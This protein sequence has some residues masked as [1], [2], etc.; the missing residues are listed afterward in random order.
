MKCS[1]IRNQTSQEIEGVFAE[2]GKSSKLYSDLVDK[3]NDPEQALDRWA[4][5]LTPSFADTYDGARDE[6]GEPT[7]DEVI[8]RG[9]IDLTPQAT[10]LK[11][12]VNK[13]AEKTSQGYR[14][15]ETKS[16]IANRVTDIVQKYRDDIRAYSSSDTTAADIGTTVHLL[17]EMMFRHFAGEKMNKS[18]RIAKVRDHLVSAGLPTKWLDSLNSVQINDLEKGMLALYEDIKKTQRSIDPEGKVAILTEHVVHNKIKDLAGTIDV[19]IVYSNGQT[20]TLD[21]KTM[22][23]S[24]TKIG[25]EEMVAGSNKITEWNIQQSNYKQMLLDILGIED[26]RESRIIPIAVDY[27]RYD[28]KSES[29]VNLDSIASITMAGNTESRAL[30]PIP[31]AG[32]LTGKPATDKA[33]KSLERKRS[34]LMTEIRNAKEYRKKQLLKTKIN[35]VDKVLQNLRLYDDVKDATEMTSNLI[36]EIERRMNIKEKGTRSYLV[37][38]DIREYINEI[39]F[40]VEILQSIDPKSD[41][42]EKLSKMSEKEMKDFV[43]KNDF[44]KIID[45]QQTLMVMSQAQNYKVVLE[46]LMLDRMNEEAGDEVDLKHTGKKPGMMGRLFYGIASSDSPIFQRFS[47]LFTTARD[48]AESDTFEDIAYIKRVDKEFIGWAKSNGMT[49]QE[50]FNLLINNKTK[51]LKTSATLEYYDDLKKARK[52]KDML[53]FENN[54]GFNEEAFERDQEEYLKIFDDPSFEPSSFFYINKGKKESDADFKK[55]L[56]EKVEEAK[57]EFKERNDVRDNNIGAY[58]TSRYI[59]PKVLNTK[60][61]S[62]LTILAEKP[63]NEAFKNYYNMYTELNEKYDKLTGSEKKIKRNFIANV[64][65]D[66]TDRMFE[67]GFSE[68]VTGL[69]QS[70]THSLKIREQDEVVG[71]TDTETGKALKSVPILYT[72]EIKLPLTTKEEN[73]IKSAQKIKLTEEFEKAGKNVKGRDFQKALKASTDNALLAEQYKKGK[74]IKSVDLT[75]S[76]IMFASSVHKFHAMKNIEDDVMTLRE[77]LVNGDVKETVVDEYGRPLKDTLMG[78]I[79]DRIGVDAD[80]ISLFDNYVD[81]LLYGKSGSDKALGNISAQKLLNKFHSYLSLKALALNVPLGAANYLGAS[82]N[83]KFIAGEGRVFNEDDLKYANKLAPVFKSAEFD[84]TDDMSDEAI[85]A[86]HAIAFFRPA[87]RDLVYEEAEKNSASWGKQNMTWR[88]AFV[89]HR[90][91]DNAIDN[92]ILIA[93]MKSHGI[94]STGKLVRRDKAKEDFTPLIDMKFEFDDKSGK[95]SIMHKGADVFKENPD[96]YTI[97]RNRVRKVAYN[98]KGSLSE[99]QTSAHKANMLFQLSMKFRSWMPGMIQSRFGETKYDPTLDDLEVG[100]YRAFAGMLFKQGVS[101]ALNDLKTFT[102]SMMPLMLD[103]H[104]GRLNGKYA[105]KKYQQFLEIHPHL[106]DKF[107]KEDFIN[108][109][110]SKMRGLIVEARSAAAIAA[111]VLFL[112]AGLDWDDPDENNIITRNLFLMAKRTAL[113]LSFPYSPSSVTELMKM[114]FP[115]MTLIRDMDKIINNGVDETRDYVF[116]EN[117]TRDTTPMLY[118]SAKQI[119]LINQVMNLA[120]VFNP[121][122]YETEESITEQII[123]DLIE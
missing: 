26:L 25:K 75:A 31:V 117:Q 92:K 56:D 120:G 119:P 102:M 13:T 122:I 36:K 82:A 64:S 19:I 115:V 38:H 83:L 18:E 98:T 46:G 8:A 5:T 32:E 34:N 72:D 121:S 28:E 21:F 42:F 71:R 33:I 24:K 87:T 103:H 45:T 9:D 29:M 16:T 65:Q 59:I 58:S 20:G 11:K 60:Y 1:I 55:R 78:K 123:E 89:L 23:A 44:K 112:S 47:K 90:L 66:M 27:K 94:D 17:G 116:G 4:G 105:E 104:K 62:E 99:E 49:K 109:M 77:I 37:P 97:I 80:T 51:N 41:T 57:G 84:S 35:K 101:P 106:K 114:P 54:T 40:F 113:E 111:L 48:Q 14:D 118:Y 12:L 61:A 10:V 69:W 15:I 110:E 22:Y 95:L 76:M 7:I 100:R 43:G 53:W 6:N 86:A 108:L 67:V 91:G 70:A 52:E 79:A 68:G 30:D 73:Q 85:K 107:S 63:G 3:L 50:A 93:M 88:N 74:N 96:M 2:N 81:T 39:N